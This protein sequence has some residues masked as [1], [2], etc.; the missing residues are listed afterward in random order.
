MHFDFQYTAHIQGDIFAVSLAM[1]Q[2]SSF[3]DKR[4]TENHD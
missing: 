3:L 4:E 2:L 1:L